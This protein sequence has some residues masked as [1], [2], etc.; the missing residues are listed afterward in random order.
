MYCS[1]VS[2]RPPLTRGDCVSIPRPCPRRLCRYH[3]PGGATH[4]ALDEAEKGG[5]GHGTI[6]EILQLSRTSVQRIEQEA[7]QK[8]RS[9]VG[10]D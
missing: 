6:A 4:C 7:L 8:L 3:V 10:Q 5:Q 2:L 9:Y 1:V